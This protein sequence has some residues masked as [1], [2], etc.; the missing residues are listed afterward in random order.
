MKSFIA[1]LVFV[2]SMFVTVPAEASMTFHGSWSKPVYNVDG[3]TISIEVIK[4]RLEV[5]EKP[6]IGRIIEV[7]SPVIGMTSLQGRFSSL[8]E[9]QDRVNEKLRELETPYRNFVIIDI[10]VDER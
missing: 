6:N 10:Y 1:I 9:F 7:M 5:P 2:V 4:Y 3:A 8:D